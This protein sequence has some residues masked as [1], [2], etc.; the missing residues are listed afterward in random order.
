MGLPLMPKVLLKILNNPP[1]LYV[2]QDEGDQQ[3]NPFASSIAVQ[4]IAQLSA[5]HSEI[6]LTIAPFVSGLGKLGYSAK[7]TERLRTLLLFRDPM[8]AAKEAHSAFE[9]LG[10]DYDQSIAAK[11][12]AETVEEVAGRY[13]AAISERITYELLLLA[14]LAPTEIRSDAF[15]E[16]GDPPRRMS[17]R[18][19]DYFWSRSPAGGIC[20]CKNQP[21]T[22]LWEFKKKDRPGEGLVWSKS[23][24]KLMMDVDSM[25]RQGGAKVHSA[26]VTLRSRGV[27][28]VSGFSLPPNLQIYS[29]EELNTQFRNDVSIIL[30]L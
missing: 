26:C 10:K 17:S 30:N 11:D 6:L 19:L 20:E 2:G 7:R 15:F 14:G 29:A 23:K 5:A 18:N 27:I 28:D 4:K 24:C 25:L 16:S 22:L 13:T 21:T 1:F 9:Q 3:R 8:A 12:P